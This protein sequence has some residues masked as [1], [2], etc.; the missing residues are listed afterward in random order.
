M[1]IGV[2]LGPPGPG[3]IRLLPLCCNNSSH[4]FGL[5]PPPPPNNCHNLGIPLTLDSSGVGGRLVA[6]RPFLVHTQCRNLY[7]EGAINYGPAKVPD[8]HATMNF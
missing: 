2:W 5:S 6:K 4:R 3:P 7:A 8:E 1:T